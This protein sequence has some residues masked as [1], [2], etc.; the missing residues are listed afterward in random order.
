MVNATDR[1]L[2]RFF[3]AATVLALL[4]IFG[5]AAAWA[6]DAKGGAPTVVIVVDR[7]GG[8]DEAAAAIGAE[9]PQPWTRADAD[10]VGSAAKKRNLPESLKALD[11]PKTKGP[12]LQKLAQVAVDV[13]ARGAVVV[14]I[15]KNREGRVDL[16]ST[17]GATLVDAPVTL[18]AATENAALV[19]RRFSAELAAL[20]PKEEAA[21]KPE[22]AAPSS[23]A[24]PPAEASKPAPDAPPSTKPQEK[25]GPEPPPL[26][27]ATVAME[28]ANRNLSYQD[29]V[30]K[31]IRSD[32]SGL[33]PTPAI[34]ADVF[35]LARSGI[36][37]LQDIGIS[38]DVKL[39]IVGAKKLDDGTKASI[40]WTR[41]DAGLKYRI[42]LRRDWKA[43]MLAASVS[44]GQ[45]SVH[46]SASTPPAEPLDTPSVAY[47]VL[48]PRVDLRVPIGPIAV[49]AGGGY[50]AVLKSGD[51]AGRFRNP[52]VLGWEADL[53]LAVP[54]GS[55]F[56]LRGGLEARRFIF[57]FAP[58]AGD[59]YIA[60]AAH[61]QI[62]RAHLGISVHL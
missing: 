53:A 9:L 4:A 47:E 5:E 22:T 36:L 11:G 61:D 21:P 34:A 13:G 14:Q 39:G 57:L 41:F 40:T 12:Y 43:P 55:T 7:S 52:S 27:V 60:S 59:P 58:A 45:E 28:L 8:G 42:W 25:T 19:A 51:L 3:L 46:F 16:I 49:L 23:A 35:P 33:A 10:A 20:L 56:E 29:V 15:R 17:A 62:L 30:T 37:V 2:A 6:K 1:F 48:R 44:Y 54:I 32:N 18:G 38:G 31:N 26:L 24:D 50:L